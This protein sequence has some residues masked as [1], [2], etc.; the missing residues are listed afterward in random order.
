MML[1]HEP[2]DRPT[3]DQ[4]LRLPI[5]RPHI[6]RYEQMALKLIEAKQAKKTGVSTNYH[7]IQTHLYTQLHSNPIACRGGTYR[8]NTC[9]VGYQ[10]HKLE[11]GLG[12]GQAYLTLISQTTQHFQFCLREYAD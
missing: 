6:A 3:A 2:E 7:P 1:Q 4:L 9:R 10:V 8:E 5:L 11:L 12:S